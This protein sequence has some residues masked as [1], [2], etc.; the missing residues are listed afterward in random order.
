M[1]IHDYLK[2]SLD[3]AKTAGPAQSVITPPQ[4]AGFDFGWCV[5][6]VNPNTDKK[7]KQIYPA[8]QLKPLQLKR[9]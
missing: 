8:V 5:P 9:K 6:N 3:V 2:V 7:K 4:E 1:A